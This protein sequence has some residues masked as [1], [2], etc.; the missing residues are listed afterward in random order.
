M[1]ADRHRFDKNEIVISRPNKIWISDNGGRLR[2]T[3]I[4]RHGRLAGL[5]IDTKFCPRFADEVI[6]S[7]PLLIDA[8]TPSCR[9][10]IPA[11]SIDQRT[12]PATAR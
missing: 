10:H 5:R 9:R 2:R 12:R 3:A 11:L 6:S 1:R 8:G 7:R 4:R